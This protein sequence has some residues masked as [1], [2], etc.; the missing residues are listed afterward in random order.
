MAT[1][2]LLVRILV[3]LYAAASAKYGLAHVSGCCASKSRGRWRANEA[4]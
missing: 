1:Q 2:K 4:F 3:Y